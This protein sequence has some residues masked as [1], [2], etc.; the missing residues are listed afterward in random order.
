MQSVDYLI[1]GG[2]I[3]GTTA[4]ETIRAHDASSS[5]VILEREPHPLYSRVLIPLYLKK[6]IEREQLFLR[7][8]ADY[9][10]QRIGFY[11][12]AVMA[13]CDRERHEISALLG[14]NG[15]TEVFSYK[16]LLLATGG[17]PRPLPASLSFGDVVPLLRMQTLADADAIG[18]V[19]AK[20]PAKEAAVL[21]E[22]FVAME[23]IETFFI[24]GFRVHVLC[25]GGFFGEEKLGVH[26]ARL[27][28]EIYQKHGIRFYKN[29]KDDE[30]V[31]RE[32]W[33]AERNKP[34]P[35]AM[36]G[37][38]VGLERSLEIFVGLATN[39]GVVTDE[40]LQTS[41]ADIYAAGDIAEW[42]D[43]LNERHTLVGN[44]TNAFLQGKTAALNMMGQKTPLWVVSTYHIVNFGVDCALVG[45]V[46]GGDDVWEEVGTVVNPFLRRVVFRSGKTIGGVLINRFEDKT[47]L[48]SF[49]EA[50]ASRNDVEKIFQST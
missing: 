34:F 48:A 27:L 50:G 22:G 29:I 49:V 26:G 31:R 13:G 14:R 46:E 6:K 24:N 40:Y 17:A 18:D 16:K 5:I 32:T 8:T 3:A 23:F 25:R 15:S 35:I 12:D 33:L 44:W 39:H 4:A 38:G 1:V 42:Y 36:V 10:R 30:I 9:E 43:A 21:G 41:N 20:A 2:G 28:E 7:T 19:M 37:V 11:P 45:D 47:R